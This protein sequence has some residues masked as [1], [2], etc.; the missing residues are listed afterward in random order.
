M[1]KCDHGVGYTP[2]DKNAEWRLFCRTCRGARDD[3][4]DIII[5]A[6]TW[7]SIWNLLPDKTKTELAEQS[8]YELF[9]SLAINSDLQDFIRKRRAE[10][11]KI[12]D[13]WHK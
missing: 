10:G 12:K 3:S 2:P 7:E 9:N 6:S 5:K 8:A 11:E 4:I 13:R 1:W